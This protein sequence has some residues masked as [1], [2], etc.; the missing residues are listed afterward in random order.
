VTEGQRPVL[1]DTHY[2]VWLQFDVKERIPAATLKAINAAAASGLLLLS[3]MSVWEVAMLEA[4]G[5]LQ[6][7][8][9]CE[10]WVKRALATPGLTLV[11]LTPEIAIQSTRLPGT[12]HGDPSDRIIAATTRVMGA[13]LAT[14]DERL[15]DYARQRHIA[16]C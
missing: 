5:R 7:F 4:K 6:L 3:A 8:S 2:W 14:C 12:I 9:E 16:L 11:P 1:L 13:R 10:Q 15:I